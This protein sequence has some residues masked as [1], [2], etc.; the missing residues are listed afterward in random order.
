VPAGKTLAESLELTAFVAR[1][2]PIRHDR[3]AVRWLARYLELDGLAIRDV[4]LVT[5]NLVALSGPKREHGVARPGRVR[6]V[7]AAERAA[8]TS[9]R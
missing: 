3:Y 1:K 7:A 8:L 5:K 9:L 2:D 4:E 6:R